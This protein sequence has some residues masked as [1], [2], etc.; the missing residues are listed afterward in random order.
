MST[1]ARRKQEM[2]VFSQLFARRASQEILT[3]EQLVSEIRDEY[4][5]RSEIADAFEAKVNKGLSFGSDAHRRLTA[6][7]NAA[8]QQIGDR[9]GSAAAALMARG[10]P[11]VEQIVAALVAFARSRQWHVRSASGH[12]LDWQ[13]RQRVGED[14]G[15]VLASI[16]AEH[17]GTLLVAAL[18][19]SDKDVRFTAASALQALKDSRTVGPLIDALA[20]D[21]KD[22]CIAVKSALKAI[23]GREADAALA[24]HGATSK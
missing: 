18:A 4:I 20:D 12:D 9:K 13:V 3:E 19:D 24:K 14:I 1:K 15:E 6:E 10:A 17:A 7:T 8:I 23:G 5:A 22:V 11:V 2:G 21:S 16:G